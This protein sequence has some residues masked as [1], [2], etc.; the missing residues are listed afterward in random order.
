MS[1]KLVVPAFGGSVTGAAVS[2]W[3]GSVGEK[4]DSDEPIVELETGFVNVGVP[5]PSDG[6]LGGIS[7]L[8][9]DTV[10]VG[11]LLGSIGAWPAPSVGGGEWG[12]TPPPSA[13][14]VIP[15]IFVGPIELHSV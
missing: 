15:P 4:V 10:A 2:L 11:A 13:E 12:Y 14:G 3:L 9:G 8:G 7:V 6:V 5:S 1:E